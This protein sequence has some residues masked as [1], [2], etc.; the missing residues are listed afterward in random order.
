MRM[1]AARHS[2]RRSPVALLVLVLAS[3]WSSVAL[4]QAAEKPLVSGDVANFAYEVRTDCFTEAPLEAAGGIQ[5]VYLSFPSPLPSGVVENDTVVC[6]LHL[7]AGAGPFPAMVVLHELGTPDGSVVRDIALRLAAGGY[8]ALTITLPYHITRKPPG[9]DSIDLMVSADATQIVKAFRQ[10]V[11]DIRRS[12]DWLEKRPDID[13][14]RIGVMG[15]SLGGILT[16][17]SSRVEPRFRAAVDVV[18][19]GDLA[20]VVWDGLLTRGI[21]SKLEG[22]GVTRDALAQTLAPI[23]P[24]SYAQ[25]NQVCRVLMICARLD[26]VMPPACATR[27]WEAFGRPQI[28]WFLAGHYD[29]LFQR[30]KV[31][32]KTFEFLG[33]ALAAN[34]G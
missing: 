17:L 14:N 16:L 20:S 28:E 24:I 30:G 3:V 1:A 9:Q 15:V 19:A 33:S 23:D 2:E 8:A 7:P 4:G 5:R 6:V 21:R 12:V 31:F 34:A 29:I 11:V 27:T 10:A 32:E 18:G 26:V 22:K 25:C 13:G